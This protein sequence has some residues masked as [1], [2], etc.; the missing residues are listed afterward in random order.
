M[1]VLRFP[2][3]T[4]AQQLSAEL[5]ASAQLPHVASTGTSLLQQS[6]QGEPSQ[7]LIVSSALC[8]LGDWYA[9]QAL[10]GIAQRS[11]GTGNNRSG[12]NA[13][14]SSDSTTS[15]GS[16]SNSDSSSGSTTSVGSTAPVNE[17]VHSTA[18]QRYNQAAEVADGALSAGQEQ[19]QARWAGGL[20]C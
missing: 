15:S 10:G 8:T 13:S 7:P 5:A 18:V 20:G 4:G 6:Q 3:C 2:S 17:E 9:A 11:S 19:Q 12:S 14:S 16:S 1:T